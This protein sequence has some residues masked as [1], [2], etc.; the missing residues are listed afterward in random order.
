ME[1]THLSNDVLRQLFSLPGSSPALLALWKCGNELLNH[2]IAHSVETILLED[3]NPMSTSRLPTMLPSLLCLRSVRILRNGALAP[4]SLLSEVVYSL[5]RTLTELEIRCVGAH[6]ALAQLPPYSASKEPS[7]I[8]SPFMVLD[9]PEKPLLLAWDVKNRFPALVKLVLLPFGGV[10]EVQV[11]LSF[12]SDY[13]LWSSIVESLPA[14]IEHVG[15]TE[16]DA[17]EELRASTGLLSGAAH[18]G[19]PSLWLSRGLHSSLP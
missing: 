7:D 2:K 9:T 14:T 4:W 11:A 16:V 3:A 15:L 13:S 8:F 12:S 6:R 18:L 5:P 19:I 1:L 17:F 10:D